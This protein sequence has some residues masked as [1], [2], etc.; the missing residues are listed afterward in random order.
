MTIP[1]A[2][3]SMSHL[4]SDQW[5]FFGSMHE[6]GLSDSKAGMF[7]TVSCLA[8]EACVQ[9]SERHRTGW[10][11][12]GRWQMRARA[13][14]QREQMQQRTGCL[15]P[16]KWRGPDVSRPCNFAKKILKLWFSMDQHSPTW[17][18]DLAC[19]QWLAFSGEKII[20]HA[21]LH[22]SDYMRRREFHPQYH[23]KMLTEN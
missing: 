12:W 21:S 2:S 1:R 23:L 4:V 18:L 5:W 7:A 6:V 8:C 10:A 3:Y 11:G 16:Y 13:L 22:C 9:R 19:G 17:E 20:A 14:T 15:W